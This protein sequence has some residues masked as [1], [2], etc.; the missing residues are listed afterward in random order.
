MPA[1]FSIRLR[2]FFDFGFPFFR[3]LF[4]DLV[5]CFPQSSDPFSNLFSDIVRTRRRLPNIVSYAVDTSKSNS[6]YHDNTIAD[7]VEERRKEKD[8]KV[9]TRSPK[10]STGERH[11]TESEGFGIFRFSV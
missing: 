9:L 3:F 11:N 7:R 1:L 6:K 4:S 2:Q 10:P 8:P 5:R